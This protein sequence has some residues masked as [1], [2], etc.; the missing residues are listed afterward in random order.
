M[1]DIPAS[2]GKN[3]NL[4]GPN[5]EAKSDKFGRSIGDR[6]GETL[7]DLPVICPH[8]SKV[9]SAEQA[10]GM[11]ACAACGFSLTEKQEATSAPA[12]PIA[13]NIPKPPRPGA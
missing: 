8:C 1:S 10:R 12:A 11:E 2:D 4:G 3:I 7:G 9:Y 6:F 5:G 13:P